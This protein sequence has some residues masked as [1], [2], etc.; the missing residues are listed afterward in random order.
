VKEREP[1]RKSKPVEEALV[2]GDLIRFDSDLCP[3]LMILSEH[4]SS[5]YDFRIRGHEDKLEVI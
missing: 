5:D 3:K 2:E 4:K 1:E